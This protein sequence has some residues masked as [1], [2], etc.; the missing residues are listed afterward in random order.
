T[1]VDNVVEALVL[2]MRAPSHVIG[3]K[4]NITNGEPVQL[5]ALLKEMFG[6]L[7][8]TY[9]EKHIPFRRAYR[10]AGAM[11]FTCRYF[12]RGKEPLLT[13]YSVCA[14]GLSRT[15]NIEAARRDLNYKPVV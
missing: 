2:A 11:E 9:R 8:Y 6:A 3:R 4:Y 10:L 5:Y 12:L 1:Y 15:L 7:G 13:R 14:L